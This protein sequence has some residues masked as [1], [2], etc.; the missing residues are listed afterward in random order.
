[1]TNEL[2]RLDTSLTPAARRYL[3][4][5]Q[6]I[7]AIGANFLINYLVAWSSFRD[8]PVVPIEGSMSLIADTEATC[9]FLP[10]LA[11]LIVSH[12]TGFEIQ[13]GRFPP[14]PQFRWLRALGE[15]A[16]ASAFPKAIFFGVIGRMAL[17]PILVAF[18][19]SLELQEMPLS[20]FLIVKGAIG[21]G[22]GLLFCPL[23]AWIAMHTD[24]PVKSRT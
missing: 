14:L 9:F 19:R 3:I 15:Y 2:Q 5:D 16:A 6:G 4:V 11:C 23:F 20:T 12:L 1:M 24:E 22:L 17:A 21:A 10:F 18:I 8:V 13:R 7:M